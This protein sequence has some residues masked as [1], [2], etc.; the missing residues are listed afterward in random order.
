M[1]DGLSSATVKQEALSLGADLVGITR[2][3]PDLWNEAFLKTF[4]E[5]KRH[6]D[7]KYLENYSLR[8]HPERLLKNAKSIIVIAVNYY[9]DAKKVPKGHGRIARYAFGRDYHKVMKKLLRGLEA[10]IKKHEPKARTRICVDAIPL[11]EKSY[12]VKAGLGFIGKNTMLITR[13]FGS[14]VL[15]GELLTTLKLE[16]DKP[17]PGTCG[18]CTRCIKAC[19]GGALQSERQMNA[20]RCNS[21]LTIEKKGPIPKKYH[22]AMGD[23]IFGCDI[24]QEVC[25]YNKS[26]AKKLKNEAFKKVKIAGSSLNLEKILAIRNDE[27]FLQRFAGSPLMRA[28]KAGLQRNARI[29]A[30]NAKI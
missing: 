5:E 22:K 14:F 25:P 10:F 30:G 28:K 21:Y 15:L 18:T 27:E 16:P 19:P 3:E 11:L 7:M 1:A 8:V 13:Q 20:S 29:A 4:I 24:C 6:G 23:W 12:A 9:R 26:D 17:I 2:A